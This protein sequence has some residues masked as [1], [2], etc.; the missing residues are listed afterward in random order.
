MKRLLWLLFTTLLTG[1]VTR[2]IVKLQEQVPASNSHTN[3]D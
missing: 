1:C 3:R 2:T